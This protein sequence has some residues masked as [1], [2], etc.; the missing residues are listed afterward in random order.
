MNMDLKRYYI[1][2]GKLIQNLTIPVDAQFKSVVDQAKQRNFDF[3]SWA[4]D[5]LI[6]HIKEVIE[7][8]DIDLPDDAA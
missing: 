4:R 1:G 8:C 5:V 7:F 2:H 6:S 3:N